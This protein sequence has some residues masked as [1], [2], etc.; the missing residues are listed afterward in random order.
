MSPERRSFNNMARIVD[1]YLATWNGTPMD[2]ELF[3]ALR[4]QIERANRIPQ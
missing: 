1:A 2:P 3:P 4:V